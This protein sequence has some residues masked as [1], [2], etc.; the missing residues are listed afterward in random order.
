MP[1][2]FSIYF[3][4]ILSPGSCLLMQ[5]IFGW[6]SH[7]AVHGTYAWL[8]L[9]VALWWTNR[10]V[11]P[12]IVRLYDNC[13]IFRSMQCLQPVDP[14]TQKMRYQRTYERTFQAAT[15]RFSPDIEQRTIH[16]LKHVNY[17]IDFISYFDCLF[18]LFAARKSW[19]NIFF[20]CRKWV[21][22]IIYFRY[23]NNFPVL[24]FI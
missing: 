16:L 22:S 2:H 9:L 23:F 13:S 8:G 5:W 12:K 19:Y 1:S 3:F 18:D 24:F 14:D 20:T 10:F 21:E 11:T 15:E 6:L 17:A 4:F 7:F